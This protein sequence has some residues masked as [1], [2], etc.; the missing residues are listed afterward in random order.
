[1]EAPLGQH[2]GRRRRARHHRQ[3]GGGRVE[4]DAPPR[5]RP[6]RPDPRGQRRRAR[7]SRGAECG[8]RGAPQRALQRDAGPR[9]RGKAGAPR[10]RAGGHCRGA[11]RARPPRGEEARGQG[12][13]GGRRRQVGRPGCGPRG[14]V[15]GGQ[16]LHR[17]GVLCR[18]DGPAAQGP[19]DQG[20]GPREDAQDGARG[21]PRAL[22]GRGRGRAAQRAP[23]AAAQR[24]RGRGPPARRGRGPG[25]GGGGRGRRGRPHPRGAGRPRA[26]Q[27]PDQ[28]QH[29]RAGLL[30]LGRVSKRPEHLWVRSLM[31]ARVTRALL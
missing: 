18:P 2:P 8:R 16:R 10:A 15:V 28:A 17:Q 13:E 4:A 5:R 29:R 22:P 25:V 20:Q 3:A 9:P 24:A 19:L 6:A 14:R 27:V 31:H 23:R 30:G 11:R 26:A 21:G 7:R 1:M 12:Q